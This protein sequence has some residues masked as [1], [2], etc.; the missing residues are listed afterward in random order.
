MERGNWLHR[1]RSKRPIQRADDYQT[2]QPRFLAK[3]FHV[4]Y[5]AK[6]HARRDHIKCHGGLFL[7]FPLLIYVLKVP[8]R[9]AIG[10]NLVIAVLS[11][12][13]GFLG[14]LLTGQIHFLMAFAVVS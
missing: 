8:T 12:S 14:K 4:R 5:D 9:I 2:L 13:S 3:S 6:D 1:E 10:S 11:T 7:I